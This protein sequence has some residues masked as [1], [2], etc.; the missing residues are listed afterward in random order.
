MRHQPAGA[1]IRVVFALLTKIILFD[2]E[3]CNR[4]IERGN[5]QRFGRE[6]KQDG[7]RAAILE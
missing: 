2:I 6:M 7:E 1:R 4:W 5:Y 3:N